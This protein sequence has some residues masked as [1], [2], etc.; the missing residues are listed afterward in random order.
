MKNKEQK[1]LELNSLMIASKHLIDQYLTIE[2]V[3]DSPELTKTSAQ[4]AI[5][6]CLNILGKMEMELDEELSKENN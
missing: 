6:E 5:W 1:K 3:K 4:K 2:A